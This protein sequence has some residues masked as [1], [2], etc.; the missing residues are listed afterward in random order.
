VEYAAK[1]SIDYIPRCCRC[2]RRYAGSASAWNASLLWS[3]GAIRGLRAR[4][5]LDIYLAQEFIAVSSRRHGL[6]AEGVELELLALNHSETA[7]AIAS[8]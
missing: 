4:I 8:A 2:R 6:S 3:G 7:G 5:D 1:V